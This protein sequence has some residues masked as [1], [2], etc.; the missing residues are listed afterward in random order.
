MVQNDL[1]SLQF[2]SELSSFEGQGADLLTMDEPVMIEP[3]AANCYTNMGKSPQGVC[4]S[5]INKSSW[6]EIVVDVNMMAIECYTSCHENDCHEW[7]AKLWECVENKAPSDLV[8]EDPDF[9]PGIDYP[10]MPAPAG[11]GILCFPLLLCFYA[12]TLSL[13]HL[14]K[15]RQRDVVPVG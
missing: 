7:F 15:R 1:G 9:L 6:A 5:E 8:P 3:M 11:E 12:E 13:N 10:V 2:V 4:S 14:R